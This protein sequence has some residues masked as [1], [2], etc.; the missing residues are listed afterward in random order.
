MF[1]RKDTSSGDLKDVRDSREAISS[2]LD[3]NMQIDGNVAFRGKARIDG[4]VRGNVSGEYLILSETGCVEGDVS[5]EVLVCHGT[6]RGDLRAA[7]LTAKSSATISGSLEVQDFSV[8]SGATLS[9]EIRSVPTGRS[10][11]D[12]S[13]EQEPPAALDSPPL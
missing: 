6:I 5:V 10:A 9:G 8:E 1:N 13:A 11:E 2:V 4:G 12:A 7:V 3:E